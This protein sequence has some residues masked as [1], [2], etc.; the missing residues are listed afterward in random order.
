[1][2]FGG[3]AFGE[4]GRGSN[5]SAFARCHKR[6]AAADAAAFTPAPI[7]NDL[8]FTFRAMVP[9]ALSP[10]LFSIWPGKVPPLAA[11][12]RRSTAI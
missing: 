5:P 8:L 3:I 4:T 6:E 12:L 9:P 1:M 10:I 7:V 2:F 11:I